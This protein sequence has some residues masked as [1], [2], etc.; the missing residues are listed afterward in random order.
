L[1]E[2]VNKTFFRLQYYISGERKN[3][4]FLEIAFSGFSLKPGRIRLK[5]YPAISTW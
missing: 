5:G 4:R 1:F 2:N 3:I